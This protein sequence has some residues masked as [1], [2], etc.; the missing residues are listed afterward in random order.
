MLLV[1]LRIGWDTGDI[2]CA[3]IC[4]FVMGAGRSIG[5][6]CRLVREGEAIVLFEDPIDRP[7]AGDGQRHGLQLGIALQVVADGLGSGDAAQALS[8]SISNS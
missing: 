5:S 8:R 4:Q 1:A 7:L 2:E 6:C 3:S